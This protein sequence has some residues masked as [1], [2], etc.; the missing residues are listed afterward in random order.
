MNR[1]LA[2]L[3]L[4]SLVLASTAACKSYPDRQLISGTVQIDGLMTDSHGNVSY[5][6]MVNDLPVPKD[7]SAVQTDGSDQTVEVNLYVYQHC[8]RGS[9]YPQ[10]ATTPNPTNS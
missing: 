8:P 10:C 9:F 3:A 4:A 2:S 6:L 5:E 1:R 7:A